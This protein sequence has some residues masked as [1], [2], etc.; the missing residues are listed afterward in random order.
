MTFRIEPPLEAR[1]KL[2]IVLLFAAGIAAAILTNL[3]TESHLR[4]EARAWAA[5]ERSRHHGQR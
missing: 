2:T 4:E 3:W 5:Q 1:H